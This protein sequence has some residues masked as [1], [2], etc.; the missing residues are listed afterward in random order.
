VQVV[1][2]RHGIAVDRDDPE[3]PPDE[4]RPLTPRGLRRTRA[5]ATGLRRL[6]VAPALILTSRLVR[7][8]HTAE[9]AADVLGLS[10]RRIRETR[11]LAPDALPDELLEEVV[12][13]KLDAVLCVGH[14]PGLDLVLAEALGFRDRP[15]VRLK[16]AGAACLA[17]DP[18]NG[19]Q[20]VWVL[21]PSALRALGT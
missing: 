1:L 9:I 12:E 4:L 20:L 17:L 13:L 16:K 18:A 7:A 19:S 3:C 6:S 2:F 15:P 10:P 21:E 8:R 11:A 5:A 14:A